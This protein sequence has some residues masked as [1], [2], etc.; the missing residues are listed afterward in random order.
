MDEP[1][2]SKNSRFRRWALGDFAAGIV[3]LATYLLVAYV[4]LPLPLPP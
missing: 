1:M 2:D 3:I 4:I